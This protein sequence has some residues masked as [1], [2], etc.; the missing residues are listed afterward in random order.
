MKKKENV[1]ERHQWWQILGCRGPE[2]LEIVH[3]EL[4]I[5]I[6]KIA[7]DPM[8]AKQHM[9]LF[10]DTIKL[11]SISND[12]AEWFSKGMVYTSPYEHN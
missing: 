5:T 3:R 4:W 10:F 11:D 12:D 7:S 1:L 6:F 9:S 2:C 8:N